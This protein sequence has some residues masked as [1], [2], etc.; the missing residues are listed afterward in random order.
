VLELV[1]TREDQ[2]RVEDIIAED[3][4]DEV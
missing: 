3:Y 1:K 4:L 2:R